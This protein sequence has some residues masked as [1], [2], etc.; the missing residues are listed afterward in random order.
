MLALVLGL[1][2]AG[3]GDDGGP[4]GGGGGGN[5]FVGTWNGYDTDGDRIRVTI[6]SSTWR[7]QGIDYSASASG[8]YTYNGNSAT[9]YSS[10]SNVGSASVSGNTL[11]VYVSSVR[12]LRGVYLS[13]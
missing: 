13:R 7:F 10:G 5:P 1:A 9:F 6:D 2:L 3:C 4:T 12:Y 8:T 11:Y